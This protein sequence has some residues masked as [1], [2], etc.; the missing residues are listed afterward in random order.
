[1]KRP[2]PDFPALAYGGKDTR[3]AFTMLEVVLA[4]ALTALVLVSLN[5]LVFSM[6]ELWGRSNEK[7]L[8]DLHVRA[9]TRY[10]EAELR[11]AGLPPY[12]SIG[13]AA[14]TLEDI[15]T[16]KSA[17][18]TVL[19]FTLPFGG[20][21]IQWPERPLP[22]VACSLLV[23]PDQGL[24]LLWYSKLENDREAEYPRETLITPLVS[25]IR[26]EYYDSE[27]MRW[28]VE[29]TP[30]QEFGSDEYTPP[31][32]IHLIF[33]HKQFQREVTFILPSATEGLPPY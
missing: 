31:A 7:R 29:D 27:T 20:R 9:V 22:E 24:Y 14:F 30:R 6:G 17:E 28:E 23:R 33:S 13:T 10:L 25:G 16:E 4:V 18:E 5:T 21:L 8:F 3:K 12:G 32:R 1:M 2:H 19:S 11:T 15:E 26:Y